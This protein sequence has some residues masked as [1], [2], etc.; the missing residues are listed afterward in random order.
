[1]RLI[2][3]LHFK[4]LTALLL[5]LKAAHFFQ[6]LLAARTKRL[7][8][9][10]APGEFLLI[11]AL[12]L[13]PEVGGAHRLVALVVFV[14]IDLCGAHIHM[15]RFAALDLIGGRGLLRGGRGRLLL[16]RVLLGLTL[17][18]AA[19]LLRTAV[20]LRCRLLTLRLSALCLR[21]GGLLLRGS[22]SG[23]GRGGLRLGEIV[24]DIRDLPLR[25]VMVEH[26][27]QLLIG[28]R[29]HMLALVIGKIAV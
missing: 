23:G 19:V 14:Q 5:E 28:K 25:R 2:G 18:R 9:L 20:L 22:R 21:G 4:L 12:R 8:S 13:F 1:M 16:C 7:A 6:F 3:Q 29:R 17:R 27:V 24:A 26:D 10:L 11:G 15:A